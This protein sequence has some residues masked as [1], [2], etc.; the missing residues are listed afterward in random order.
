MGLE[1]KGGGGRGAGG[2]VE[3]NGVKMGGWWV[4]ELMRAGELRGW[5]SLSLITGFFSNT[6]M[7]NSRKI[8]GND[9]TLIAN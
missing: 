7:V 5:Y 8:R 6:S 9:V 4:Q 3:A 2:E 1:G